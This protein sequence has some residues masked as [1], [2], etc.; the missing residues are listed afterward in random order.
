M[1]PGHSV[2]DG[3]QSKPHFHV[4]TGAHVTLFVRRTGIDH[5]VTFGVLQLQARG[6]VGSDAHLHTTQPRPDQVGSDRRITLSFALNSAAFSAALAAAVSPGAVPHLAMY[7]SR[8]V[9]M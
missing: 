5:P 3:Q 4:H 7:L 1:R 8:Q 2:F 6:A 9:C